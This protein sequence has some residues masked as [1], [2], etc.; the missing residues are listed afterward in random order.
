MVY[1]TD[2]G[3]GRKDADYIAIHFRQTDSCGT[4][5][6]LG[7]SSLQKQCILSTVVC[8]IGIQVLPVR[9]AAISCPR[10]NMADFK[11]QKLSSQY[12]VRTSSCSPCL[13]VA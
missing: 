6:K 4:M 2:D 13:R 9:V 11:S 1:N 3:S 8:S 5:H 7:T 10:S 12:E